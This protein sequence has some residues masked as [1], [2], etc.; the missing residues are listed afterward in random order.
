MNP[1]Y[2]VRHRMPRPRPC[3]VASAIALALALPAAAAAAAAAS[4]SGVASTFAP[5]Q[6]ASI[7]VANCNDS[8]RGSLRDAVARAVSGDLVNLSELNCSTITLTS[9]QIEIPQN[10]LYLKYSGEGGIPPTIEGNLSGRIFHHTGT[11]TLRLVGLIIRQGKY[12]NTN[13]YYSVPASGGCIYSAGSVYLIGSTVT[14][15]I[16]KDTRGEDAAGGGIYAAQSLTLKHSVVSENTAT[17]TARFADGG[18][19]FVHGAIDAEYSS[20]SGNIA[21]GLGYENFGGGIEVVNF[22]TAPSLIAN[23]TIEGNRADRGG[24]LLV[25]GSGTNGAA[26]TIRNSTISGNTANV[27]DGG[28]YLRGP[29]TLAN[30]TIA[31]NAGYRG[32]LLD[33]SGF[34]VEFESSILADNGNSDLGALANVTITGA[35]NLIMATGADVVAPPDTIAADPML[36]PLANNGGATLT[37]ALGAGS[38]AIDA[39]NNVAGLAVDQRGPGY[40]RVFGA[41]ADIGAFEWQSVDDTIFVNGFDP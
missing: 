41:A 4:T 34:A 35:N 10:D 39:G 21:S 1:R 16:A 13:V 14:S 37:H 38:P 32:L 3:A 40:P 15:C 20:V 5:H 23:S 29:V 28:A 17:S 33:S 30:S 25:S 6:P 27:E 2:F 9:G 31:F 12:D 24:G 18:G 8:G 22:G 7:V 11:G 26:V 19:V 36:A